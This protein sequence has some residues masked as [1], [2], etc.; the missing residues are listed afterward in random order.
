MLTPKLTLLSS[1]LPSPRDGR[2]ADTYPRQPDTLTHHVNPIRWVGHRNEGRRGLHTHHAGLA[3]E[4]EGGRSILA[5]YINTTM[6]SSL[7]FPIETDERTTLAISSPLTGHPS[8]LGIYANPQRHHHHYHQAN[9]HG[10]RLASE[11]PPILKSEPRR[12]G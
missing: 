10:A 5:V 1:S 3:A 2:L 6:S 7:S 11:L 12:H 8:Y 9:Y 4:R